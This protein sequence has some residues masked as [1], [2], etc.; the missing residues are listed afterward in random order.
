MPFSEATAALIDEEVKRIVQECLV[1]AERLLADNRPRL[2]ALAQALLKEDS[3]DE[4]QILA[5]TGL[6]GKEPQIA[7][8][9]TPARPL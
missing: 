6:P 3:L 5:V 7:A 8:M 9:T 1:E 4:A 2:D